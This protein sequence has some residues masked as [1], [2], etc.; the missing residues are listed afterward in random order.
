M[1]T[2]QLFPSLEELRLSYKLKIIKAVSSQDT[3]KEMKFSQLVSLLFNLIN[4]EP[5]YS[6]DILKHITVMLK[7]KPFCTCFHIILL[8][9][10]LQLIEGQQLKVVD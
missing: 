5:I 1:P 4:I 9:K 2:K 10:S 8:N 6:S 7:H 3:L